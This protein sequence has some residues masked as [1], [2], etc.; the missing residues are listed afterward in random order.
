MAGN[1][2]TRAEAGRKRKAEAGLPPSAREHSGALRTS[3]AR[4]APRDPTTA[5]ESSTSRH[6]RVVGRWVARRRLGGAEAEGGGSGSASAAFRLPPG[7]SGAAEGGSGSAR[8]KRRRKPHRSQD[9][10]SPR[11]RIAVFAMALGCSTQS[12][13]D[14]WDGSL[15]PRPVPQPSRGLQCQSQAGPSILSG[16]AVPVP[17]L[18]Y[19]NEGQAEPK[20]LEMIISFL[21]TPKMN[22]Y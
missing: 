14:M 22:E 7:G 8:R 5:E 21:K 13:K 17:R 1:V 16:T 19:K 9:T 2:K 11:L 10:H 12:L 20:M 18:C 4:R 15:S 3:P 6:R